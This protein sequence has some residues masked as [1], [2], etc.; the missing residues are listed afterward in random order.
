MN[1]GVLN[2]NGEFFLLM[3]DMLLLNWL[4]KTLFVSSSYSYTK[5]D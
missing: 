3:V 2:T 5:F 1:F 4:R